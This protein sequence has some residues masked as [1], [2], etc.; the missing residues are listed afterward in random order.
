MLATIITIGDEIL[1]GQ[2][3]DTNSAFISRRLNDA[4]ITVIERSSIGDDAA[5]ITSAL[6]RALS[7]SEVVVL[8][9]G[10]GP[11]KDDI[12]RKTLASYFG[13]GLV[14]DEESYRFTAEMLAG[15]G[16]EFNELNRDQ[17]L[18]PEGST[19]FLNRN[20]TAPGTMMERG[21]RVV[22]SLPGVPF[23]MKALMD[24]S[25]MPELVRRFGLH[26][27]VHRTMIT[28]GLPESVLAQTIAPWEDALPRYMRLAYLPNP[29]AIRLRLSAYDVDAPKAGKEIKEQ[30]AKLEKIIGPYIIGYGETTVQEVVAGLLTERGAT[31]AVAE[32]C[33]G[34]RIASKFTEMAGASEYFLCGV[35]AYANESKV[36]VLGVDAAALEKHGAV[37]REVAERMA[38]GARRISGSDY[39]VATTGVAGPTG[40]TP[41]KPIGTVWMAV[42]TPDG[43]FSRKFLYG[44]LREQ[45]IERASSSA[46]NMLRLILL[47]KT[48]VRTLESIL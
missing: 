42:A 27:N 5:E 45:N 19:V 33:T 44:S 13:V 3:V 31:L 8:T 12:T 36:N 14:R 38:S 15:R 46:I 41:E 25:V 23:E 32:S 21:G 28:F 9:G 7:R 48:D 22:I 35:V 6:D 2:I 16:I 1:I 26:S 18:V 37:S 47:G 17:S 40:G 11:T 30:F 4:G 20:G 43:V 34:G 39:A 24:E 10:L 29:S